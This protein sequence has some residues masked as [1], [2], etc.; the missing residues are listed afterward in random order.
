MLRAAACLCLQEMVTWMPYISI[1]CVIIYVIGHAIGPSE[2]DPTTGYLHTRWLHQAPPL[3]EVL[4]GCE[5][6]CNHTWCKSRH[7]YP[8]PWG[9]L[10]CRVFRLCLVDHICALQVPFLMLWPLRCSGSQPGLLPSWSLGQST[11][12]PI[13]P[14]ASSSPSLRSVTQFLRILSHQGTRTF[15]FQFQNLIRDL[16]NETSKAIHRITSYPCAVMIYFSF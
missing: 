13:S 14:L 8:L 3:A 4:F 7:Q 9:A 11:G 6:T 15:F 16:W 2:S 10:V 5:Q 12:C 1:T